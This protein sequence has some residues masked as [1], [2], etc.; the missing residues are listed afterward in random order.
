MDGT[1]NILR[2]KETL[3]KIDNYTARC[4]Q[5][6]NKDD[7]FIPSLAGLR[8]ETGL[9]NEDIAKAFHLTQEE[10]VKVRETV[11]YKV[12]K[13][14]T[15]SQIRGSLKKAKDSIEDW[16]IKYAALNKI[17]AGVAMQQL[18]CVFKY[19]SLNAQE[20]TE[21]KPIELNIKIDK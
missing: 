10:M 11:A 2:N 15:L 8:K 3:A 14:I 6:Y 17:N 21:A 7:P 12:D 5:P 1:I 18:N 20:Q 19:L 13:T 9:S 16:Y 4:E